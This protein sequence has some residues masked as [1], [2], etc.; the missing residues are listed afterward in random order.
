MEPGSRLVLVIYVCVFHQNT[1]LGTV[2]Y[3]QGGLKLEP[4][5]RI[6][7]GCSDVGVVHSSYSIVELHSRVRYRPC[8]I[9][10]VLI[11]SMNLPQK[12]RH[13]LS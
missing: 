1:Y 10:S 9:P 2:K 7:Q 6:D 11:E 3:P 13:I 12:L 4:L 8:V 5:A